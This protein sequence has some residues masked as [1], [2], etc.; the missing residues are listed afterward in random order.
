MESGPIEK[1]V[2]TVRLRVGKNLILQSLCRTLF[3]GAVAFAVA[4]PV[5]R[6]F[7]PPFSPWWL[8]FGA[9]LGAVAAG[10][11]LAFRAFPSRLRAA[12]AADQAFGLDDELSSALTLRG[13]GGA[14]AEAFRERARKVAAGLKTGGHFSFRA[15]LE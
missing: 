8:A 14:V 2:K 15:P 12:V 13:V 10:A 1:I 11:F 7:S 9:L 4:L 6:L 3:W 5:H